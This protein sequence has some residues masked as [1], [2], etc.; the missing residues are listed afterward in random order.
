MAVS[1][2][3]MKAVFVAGDVTENGEVELKAGRPPAT[4]KRTVAKRLRPYRLYAIDQPYPTAV[5]VEDLDALEA[6]VKETY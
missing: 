3:I 4:L 2:V 1:G 6:M 5:Y